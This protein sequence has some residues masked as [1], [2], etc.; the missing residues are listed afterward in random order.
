MGGGSNAAYHAMQ[1]A[2]RALMYDKGYRPMSSDHHVAVILFVQAVH[3]SKF[4]A[5]VIKA[6]DNARKKRSESLYDA[7]APYLLPRLRI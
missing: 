7:A 5:D 4:G 6:F 1:A 3:E 2:G